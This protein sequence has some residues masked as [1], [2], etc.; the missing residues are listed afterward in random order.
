MSENHADINTQIKYWKTLANVNLKTANS[1][2]EKRRH[3]HALFFGHLYLEVLL[4]A[5]IVQHTY[6]DAP[7]GH[8]LYTLALKAALEIN[9]AQ[10]DLLTRFTAYNIT[11]RYPDQRLLLYKRFDRK[12]TQAELKKSEGWANGLCRI[13][14][15]PNSIAKIQSLCC[16]T[17]NQRIPNSVCVPLWFVC[18]RVRTS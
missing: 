2:F 5:L 16:R 15:K 18:E 6:K 7:F 1:L 11:A 13:S 8:K 10:H 4:K 14:N 12:F 9:E 3:M 17:P